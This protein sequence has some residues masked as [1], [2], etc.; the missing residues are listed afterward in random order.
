[1]LDSEDGAPPSLT[2]YLAEATCGACQ[3]SRLRPES[4]AVRVSGTRLP[5][6]AAMNAIEARRWVEGL[7]MTG[8]ARAVLDP[9]RRE[10]V[11]KL[12]FLEQVGL[13]YLSLERRGDTLSGGEAQRIRLAAS[14]GS[15]LTGVLYVLD[16]PTIGLHPVD[17]A[18]LVETLRAL[19]DLGNT[20]VVVEHD[21]ETIE[22]ADHVLDLGP[23]A[24]TQG[25]LLVA[26]GTP[27]EIA[28]HPSSRTGRALRGEGR[29]RRN[30][31]TAPDA[32]GRWLTLRAP[33]ENNLKGEDVRFPLGALTCVTGVSGSGKS[34]LV[35]DVLFQELRRRVTGAPVQPGAHAGLDGAEVV[36]RVA[37][38]DQSP[39]GRNP[40]STPA[41]Y[42][43]VWDEIRK[44]F[45]ATPEARARG[46]LPG[47]FSFNVRGG[48]CEKCEGQ[49]VLTV[50]MSFLP[51]AKVECDAC[52]GRRFNGETLE[53][54]FRGKTIADVLAMTTEEARDFFQV[55]RAIHRALDLMCR[56]DLSYL[57]LGQ[58]STTLSGGEAQRIKLVEELGKSS[59]GR[60]VYVLDEPTTGLSIPDVASLVEVL[61]L[62]V[63][64][65]DTVIVIEH[66]LDVIAEADWVVDLGPGGGAAG[67]SIVAEGSP[68][69]LAS[70]RSAKRFARSATSR[71]LREWFARWARPAAS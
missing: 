4:R 18:R 70:P 38:V 46:Y 11:P 15:H 71:F 6:I 7:R 51:D 36:E 22:A 25:G 49:G 47:R 57:A 29:G 54:R 3:G 37:E 61:H 19:R 33:T 43:G 10:L 24:G 32:S 5:E 17:S 12:A 64:R 63:E 56:V 26:R 28:R 40:R 41:T 66:H 23:G 65:G 21:E 44:V 48:R 69:T 30:S 2:K 16:E 45:A 52:G 67:G 20:V 50:E 8:L 9:I 68:L 35:R 59:S 31:R 34:T 62:L 27:A 53:V 55:H 1:M 58:S 42:T 60:S 13:G 39:I 14:L